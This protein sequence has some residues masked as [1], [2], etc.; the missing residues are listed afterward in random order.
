MQK[1]KTS[2]SQRNFSFVSPRLC[3]RNFHAKTIAV[4][5]IAC[6]A[7]SGCGP[8][9]PVP[10]SVHLKQVQA[11]IVK[12]G[13]ETN[14]LTESRTLFARLSSQTNYILDERAASKWCKGLNGITNLGDVFDYEPYKP[15]RIEVRIHNSHFDTYFIV[16]VNP[17]VQDPSGF[18]R[19]AGNVGFAK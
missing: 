7:L 1:R 14:I 2:K 16:L 3:V 18:E 12:A 11:A 10:K 13:G 17:D 15:D 4:G 5:T 6:V 9:P 8:S 19:I